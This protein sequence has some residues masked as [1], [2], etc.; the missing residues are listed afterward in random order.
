MSISRDK[1]SKLLALSSENPDWIRH[2]AIGNDPSFDAVN[3]SLT[4][5]VPNIVFADLDKQ[6]L[7]I[8][9]PMLNKLILKGKQY[10][11]T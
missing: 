3:V 11:N 10:G 7:K 4:I 1:L 5:R 8:K 6:V 9:D 2:V